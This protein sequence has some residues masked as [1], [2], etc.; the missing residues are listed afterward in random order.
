[1]TKIQQRSDYSQQPKGYAVET[2][3][4]IISAIDIVFVRGV[5]IMLIPYLLL[6][7]LIKLETKNAFL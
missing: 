4:N 5:K 3:I 1:M 2:Y 6:S 7:A